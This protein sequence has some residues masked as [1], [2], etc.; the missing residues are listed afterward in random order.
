MEDI[1]M[2]MWEIREGYT[3]RSSGKKH[4]EDYDEDEMYERGYEE[5]YRKAM[6]EAKRY[7]SEREDY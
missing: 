7:Y 6:K 4:R 2:K 3:S 5:G 1:E